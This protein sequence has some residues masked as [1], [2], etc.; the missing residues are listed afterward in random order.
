MTK[1]PIKSGRGDFGHGIYFF[2]LLSIC[3]NSAGLLYLPDEN[4]LVHTV[5]GRYHVLSVGL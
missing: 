5:A 4:A 3:G 2:Q 1:F